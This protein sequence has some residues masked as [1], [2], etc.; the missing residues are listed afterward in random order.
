MIF[1]IVYHLFSKIYAGY[2]PC[3][4]G[5][6][7][8]QVPVPTVSDW[9]LLVPVPTEIAERSQ[10]NLYIFFTQSFQSRVIFTLVFLIFWLYFQ[11]F[12]SQ[13]QNLETEY[14]RTNEL[15]FQINHLKNQET[16]FYLQI[17]KLN[18]V[19]VDLENQNKW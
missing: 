18:S 7:P 13:K 11:F 12:L 3:R 1:F 6:D 19:I 17:D 4:S 10:E 14:A 5:P 9:C 16:N 2:G 15:A 8:R